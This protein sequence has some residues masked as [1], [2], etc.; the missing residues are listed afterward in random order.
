MFDPFYLQEKDSVQTE[1]KVVKV[2]TADASIVKVTSFI[3][4]FYRFFKCCRFK[5]KGI[6]VFVSHIKALVLMSINYAS[7]SVS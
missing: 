7:T 5:N 4:L 1:F 2:A 6:V 3:L